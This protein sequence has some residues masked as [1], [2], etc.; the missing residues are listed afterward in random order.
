[1]YIVFDTY[2]HVCSIQDSVVSLQNILSAMHR[3]IQGKTSIF[4]AHRLSTIM[5]ADE[6]LVLGE[7]RVLEK[8]T[9]SDL[10]QQPSSLYAEL[11]AKQN[12][13]GWDT[14]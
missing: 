1:M 3:V 2:V 10:I 14:P 5:D 11:W 6:I 7:G 4:I 12:M 9:H 13:I 8:G